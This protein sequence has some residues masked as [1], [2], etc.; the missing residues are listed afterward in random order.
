[1]R[2]V[3]AGVVSIVWIGL[4]LALAGR[5]DPACVHR[6]ADAGPRVH[7]EQTVEPPTPK[8]AEDPPVRGLDGLLPPGAED[9]HLLRGR[10]PAGVMS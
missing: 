1:M 5:P 3:L 6:E 9:P 2:A 4:C 10:P 8:L 7:R